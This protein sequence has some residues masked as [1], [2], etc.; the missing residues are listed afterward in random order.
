ML[1]G[2]CCIWIVGE[3]RLLLNRIGGSGLS[4]VVESFTLKQ[5]GFWELNRL[6]TIGSYQGCC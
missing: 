2:C 4:M 3:L 6:V 1:L 5:S